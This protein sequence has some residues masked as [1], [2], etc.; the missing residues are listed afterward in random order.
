LFQKK[1]TATSLER[2]MDGG[3]EMEMDEDEAQQNSQTEVER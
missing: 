3:E 2:S 1:K